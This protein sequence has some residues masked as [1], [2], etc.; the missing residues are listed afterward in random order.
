KD[1][2][3]NHNKIPSQDNI[4]NSRFN[5]IT[6]AVKKCTPAIVGINVTEIKQVVYQDPF[7]GM[8]NNDP[9][10]R[11]FFRQNNRTQKYE[12]KELGT[13]FVIS[14]DGYIL[15]NHH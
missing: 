1:D 7:G 3:Q 6:T 10:F 8:F 9:F 5:A 12:I 14:P 2:D 4:S 15:T 13:G 11:Q